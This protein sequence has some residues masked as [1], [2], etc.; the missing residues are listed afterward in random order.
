MLLVSFFNL[1]LK[2]NGILA[3]TTGQHSIYTTYRQ[4]EVMFHVSTLLPFYTKVKWLKWWKGAY[5]ND[6]TSN[7]LKESDISAMIYVLLYLKM[8]THRIHQTQLNQSLIKCSLLYLSSIAL[9]R[10]HVIEFKLQQR[11]VYH[12]LCLRCL[13]LVY[14]KRVIILGN[15]SCVNVCI[16]GNVIIINAIR[17]DKCR[18]S[19]L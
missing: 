5:N 15:F 14:L 2:I 11:M 17:S 9:I 8:E 3:G 13:N 4:Y 16:N 7:T 10:K 1:K 18:E 12:H 6:R 19:K